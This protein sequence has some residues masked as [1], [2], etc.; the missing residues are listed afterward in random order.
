MEKL[1]NQIMQNKLKKFERDTRDYQHDRVYTWADERIKYRRI[2]KK[3]MSLNDPTRTLKLRPE[4]SRMGAHITV[5][6]TRFFFEKPTMAG[7]S[8]SNQAAGITRTKR[9]KQ[10]T[11]EGK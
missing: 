5:K 4:A 8:D 7:T 1:K 2:N 10:K 6:L 11:K 9:S 3:R